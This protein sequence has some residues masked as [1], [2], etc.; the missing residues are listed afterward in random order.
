MW[1]IVSDVLSWLVVALA[2][3]VSLIS[4]WAIFGF[5]P[6][7]RLDRYLYSIDRI[8]LPGT[9][10]FKILHFFRVTSLSNSYYWYETINNKRYTCRASTRQAVALQAGSGKQ[11]AIQDYSTQTWIRL[12]TM[13]AAS[14]EQNGIYLATAPLNFTEPACRTQRCSRCEGKH[15]PCN[16]VLSPEQWAPLAA[17]WFPKYVFESADSHTR[18][19]GTLLTQ[20]RPINMKDTFEMFQNHLDTL[21]D[22]G[23][24]STQKTA[25]I[26]VYW[27]D[28]LQQEHWYWGIRSFGENKEHDLLKKHIELLR[29]T[30]DLPTREILFNEYAFNLTTPTKNSPR[31]MIFKSTVYDLKKITLEDL[32]R[33]C[34]V[35]ENTHYA[36]SD[37][38]LMPSPATGSS[39]ERIVPVEDWIKIAKQ[40]FPFINWS[41]GTSRDV[42]LW[43]LSTSALGVYAFEIYAAKASTFETK[44]ENLQ[45]QQTQLELQAGF[46]ENLGLVKT[47]S[48]FNAEIFNVIMQPDLYSVYATTL[49]PFTQSPYAGVSKTWWE[50]MEQTLTETAVLVD[51]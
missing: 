23:W 29:T 39:S 27:A 45:K 34:V 5:A 48:T 31:C 28:Q 33:C 41:I 26:A 49:S 44:Q 21:Y 38:P 46:L 9:R 15:A 30:K 36:V 47:S 19:L 25:A 20:R 22:N 18:V 17:H 13:L 40:F 42:D 4:L 51:V 37:L 10:R 11:K 7:S 14:I 2:G 24:D 43:G 50:T 35:R 6:F 3:V 32:Q 16:I 8:P 12:D 1:L